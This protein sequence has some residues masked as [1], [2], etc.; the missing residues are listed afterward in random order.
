VWFHG[1]YAAG[2]ILVREAAVSAIIDFGT[3]GIGDPACDLVIA[4][5]FMGEER[6]VF[7]RAAQLDAETWSRAAG[8][9][10]WKALVTLTDRSSPQLDVQRRALTRLL[11]D[12]R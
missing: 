1:D 8:W 3:C 6:E 11:H 9:G 10:L 7:R 5:T 12:R 2:N 4:W